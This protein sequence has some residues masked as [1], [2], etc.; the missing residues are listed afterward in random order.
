MEK[1]DVKRYERIKLDDP[2]RAAKLKA[3]R[4]EFLEDAKA[5]TVL[6]LSDLMR[7]AGM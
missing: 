3:Q 1:E 5:G 6:C 7:S 4:A 2:D